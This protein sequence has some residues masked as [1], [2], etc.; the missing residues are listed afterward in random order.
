MNEK[1]KIY[2]NKG[3][4]P[5]VELIN[6]GAR[7]LLDVGCGAGD[8]AILVKSRIPDCEIKGIT[9]SATEA[10]FALENMTTCWIFD[11]EKELP[12][13]IRNHNFDTIIFSHILEHLRDPSAVLNKFTKLLGNGGVIHIAVPNVL[14]WSMR[15]KFLL[16]K[17]DYE[18]TGV[19]DDTHLRF[20]TYYSADKYLLSKSSDLEITFKGTSGSVPLWFLR[21]YLLPNTL[22]EKID[23]WGCRRWPNLFG[24]QVLISLVKR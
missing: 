3:N 21:R 10:S 14:N 18:S 4:H 23:Q 13:E 6:V 16:G 7:H 2:K 15:W 24:S 5:L 22:C 8:N 1:S 12:E 9:W 19:L 11:V 17:F 20:F